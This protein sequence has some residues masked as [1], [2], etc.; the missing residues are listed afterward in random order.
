MH[1]WLVRCTASIPPAVFKTSCFGSVVAI[2]GLL[3]VGKLHRR[4]EGAH[5][6]H[7]LKHSHMHQHAGGALSAP[8]C[9]M[10]Q[11]GCNET[12]RAACLPLWA[13]GSRSDWFE[14]C[15]AGVWHGGT[16]FPGR[17]RE[18][19]ESLT[20]KVLLVS[21]CLMCLGLTTAPS[22]LVHLHCRCGAPGIACQ[23]TSR[24]TATRRYPMHSAFLQHRSAGS[25]R[26]RDSD[27]AMQPHYLDT[28]SH[29]D[30]QLVGLAGN[31]LAS[32]SDLD[33]KS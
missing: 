12:E 29:T 8:R 15:L 7:V 20:C 25:L 33:R 9:Q 10:S 23:P 30:S 5:V 24:W 18:G 19:Q 2:R 4:E 26:F 27:I 28:L 3:S 22:H 6:R 13:A 14:G 11:T 21:T 16:G 31:L 17:R 32:K 1:G